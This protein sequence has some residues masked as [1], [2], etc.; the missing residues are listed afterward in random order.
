MHLWEAGESGRFGEPKVRSNVGYLQEVVGQDCMRARGPLSRE[1]EWAR[2]SMLRFGKYAVFRDEVHETN[3]CA[4]E[5]CGQFCQG[6]EKS[7]GSR[8]EYLQ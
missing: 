2:S 5:L 1:V 4:T 7:V 8:I 6:L 3:R